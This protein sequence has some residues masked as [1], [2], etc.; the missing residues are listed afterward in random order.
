M[1]HDFLN[2]YKTKKVISKLIENKFY[3]LGEREINIEHTDCGSCVSIPIAP[4]TA[5][6][7]KDDGDSID[8]KPDNLELDMSS[9]KSLNAIQVELEGK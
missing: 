3:D 5:T 6:K 1:D 8:F 4:D 9:V 2:L 7:I